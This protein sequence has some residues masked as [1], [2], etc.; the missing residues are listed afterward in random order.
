MH[1]RAL[2][3]ALRVLADGPKKAASV[4]SRNRRGRSFATA[5]DWMQAPGVQGL[6]IGHRVTEGRKQSELV[7]KVYVAKKLPPHDV[8]RMVPRL[9][10]IPGVGAS[11]RTDV[12]EIGELR[13]QSFTGRERPAAPGIGLSHPNC[14]NGTLGCLVRDRRDRAV[15]ILSNSHVI[16]DSGLAREGDEIFQPSGKHGGTNQDVIATFTRAIPLIF[17]DEGNPNQADAAIARVRRREDVRAAVKLIGVPI[18]IN[19]EL[20]SGMIVQK[21]GS[22]S[23]HT[24]G[25]VR[26]LHFTA[27]LHY[28]RPDGGSGRAGFRDLVLC[29]RFTDGGDSGALV[30]DMERKAVGLHFAGSELVSAFCRIDVVLDAL[31]VDLVTGEA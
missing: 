29:S 26:D 7:L 10:A 3:A 8:D 27:P 25:M 9:V 18:G 1:R 11:I 17:T 21:T 23:Q 19:A 31:A 5:R 30:L 14:G 16:G 28:K 6:G 22:A 13:L 24:V 15:Y 2:Q 4:R 12:E 20:R